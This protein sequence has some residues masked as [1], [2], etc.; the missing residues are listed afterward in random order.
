MKEITTHQCPGGINAVRIFPEGD[1]GEGGAP[2]QYRLALG[3][4]GQETGANVMLKFQNGG[5]AQ[6]GPNGITNLS[7]LAVVLDRLCSDKDFQ[8]TQVGACGI[9]R[10]REAMWWIKEAETPLN[11]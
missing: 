3:L 5:I 10:L 6:K 1:P 2:Y 7:L 9:S 8:R 11:H 4:P